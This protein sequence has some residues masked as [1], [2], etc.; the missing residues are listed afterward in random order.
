MSLIKKP[1]ELV[2]RSK[3]KALFYGQAG[4]GKT[5][6]ALS[7]P[8]P[9][10]LDFDGGVSRV[11]YTHI[12][13]TVQ[14]STFKEALDVMQEDLSDYD[15]IVVDTLG[16]MMD[17]AIIHVCGNAI[18]RIQDWSKINQ[19]F[20]SFVRIASNLNKH[21]IFIAH[22]DIRKEGEDNVFVPAVR[23]KNYSTIV[24]EL[25][26]LGYMEMNKS[27][28]QV[29]F[30]PTSRNDGKNTCNLPE[31]IQIP[32]SVD[33]DGNGIKNDFIENYIISAFEKN[34]VAR[35]EA[36]MLYTNLIEELKNEIVL[37]TDSDS[38]NDFVSRIDAWEHIG[39]SKAV[40][41]KMVAEHCKKLNLAF[42][43][44][45]KKY[46]PA[47]PKAEQPAPEPNTNSNSLV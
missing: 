35:K 42:D 4:M 8:R 14:I 15:T 36:G 17:Y 29:T 26:L 31:C 27:V 38:A 47:P 1:S 41:G 25:D 20:N 11:N 33:K 3:I 32:I 34:H 23:E 39:N 9:L 40:A 7:A 5:T 13:D 37:I 28:R 30:N 44:E 12:K 21:L 10:L 43:K 18:P 2:V 22:R 16:K 45:A 24:T 46:V 19:E 6:L